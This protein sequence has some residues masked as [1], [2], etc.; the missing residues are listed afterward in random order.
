MGYFKGAAD[1]GKGSAGCLHLFALGQN[2]VDRAST[3]EIIYCRR[4]GPYSRDLE[5]E[6]E[7]KLDL[8]LSVRQR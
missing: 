5:L 3:V 6:L 4:A 7:T 8:A 2:L 1:C